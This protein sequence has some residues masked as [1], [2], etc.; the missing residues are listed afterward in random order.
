MSTV[1]L[2]NALSSAT[3]S[4]AE[5]LDVLFLDACLMQMIEVGYE[6]KDYSQYLVASEYYGWTL[7][8]YD[9]YIS[10]ITATTT[11]EELATAIVNYYHSRFTG[12]DCAHTM[13]AA[14]L[15]QFGLASVVNDFAQALTAGLAT[16]KTQMENSRSTCQ[17]FVYDSYIDLYHFAFLIDQNIADATIQ[18]AAQAVMTAVN[19]A[20]IAE[21]HESGGGDEYYPL[22]NAYGISIY[23]PASEGDSGYINYNSGN[24]AFVADKGWDEFL[25]AFF[26]GLPSVVSVSIVPGNQAVPSGG[27]FSVDVE[28]DSAGIPI[29]ACN[30]TVTFDP[31]LTVT[32][33]TGA[34]LL[35][36]F[37]IDAFYIPTVDVGE[38]SYGGVRIDGPVA[39]DGDLVTIDF[40]VAGDATG[41]YPLV[42]EATLRDASGD[43]IAVVENDGQV[44]IVTNGR[45]GD[46]DGD[47]DIDIFDFVD[48]ADAYGSETGDPNY[49]AIGDFNDDGHIDIFDFVDFADVYGT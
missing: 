44:N 26:G 3:S 32:G 29:T 33:L 36:T 49:N 4:G 46:F 39:V 12:T 30:V 28:V 5:K 24:L 10:A 21:A 43:P 11:A 9:D 40:D 27:N 1:E 16:Y 19:N 17:K 41:T 37:G 7:G 22:Y 8:P 13:S 35:G 48:F 2:G 31:D 45:K 14:D 47:G 18:N 38:V 20:V 25:S 15:S 23:F 34:D 42:V 6:V